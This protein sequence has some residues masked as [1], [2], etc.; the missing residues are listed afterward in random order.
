M[1]VAVVGWVSNP[2]NKP[3]GLCVNIFR[4]P[5]IVLSVTVGWK[6]HPTHCYS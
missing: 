2:P 1:G 3:Q 4:L 5:E 6:A